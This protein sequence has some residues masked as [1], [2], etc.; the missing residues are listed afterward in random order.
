MSAVNRIQS[1]VLAR[2]S[3]R[4]GDYAFFN[5]QMESLF[6][7]PVIIA[8]EE[9]GVP[10]QLGEQI[11]PLLGNP[12][13]LDEALAALVKRRAA[14][15]PGLTGFERSLVRPLCRD[16]LPAAKVTQPSAS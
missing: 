13:T 11:V 1:E 2:H 6:M 3:K 8:L 4:P 16:E 7:S 14:D 10:L 12:Q 9:Y 5:G 15:I